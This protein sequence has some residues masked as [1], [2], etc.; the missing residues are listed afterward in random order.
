MISQ[1][2]IDGDTAVVTGASQGIGEAIAKKFADDGV[3]VAIC[4]R[5]RDRF[6]SVVDDI[7]DS[8]REGA[9][10]AAEVDVRDRERVFEFVD[11][12]VDEFGGIDV[13]VNN[14]G[15]S[16]QAR[17]QDLSENAWKT[18]IDIN[19]HGAVHFTQAA[20][21]VMR[22]NDGGYIV[23]II[24]GAGLEGGSPNMSQYGAAKAGLKNLTESLADE[25][26]EYD[27]RTNCIA[28]GLIATPGV[29]DSL[30]IDPDE[31]PPRELVDR[32]IGYPEETADLA[33][34]LCSPAASYLNGSLIRAGMPSSETP[35]RKD[36]E[37]RD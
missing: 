32:Y 8:S 20:G 23:N 13:L 25:W 27:I 33:Q 17:F 30:G 14:A 2:H 28:P 24:S 26:K 37:D 4:S 22:E 16:F 29:V 7:N 6:Q 9:V 11:E 19:L 15:G 35:E 36:P 12:V 18:I 21:E 5:S 3:D 34:F 1:F 31:M 10:Y